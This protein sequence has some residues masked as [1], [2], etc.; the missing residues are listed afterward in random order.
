MP[1]WATAQWRW[2][3]DI[4]ASLGHAVHAIDPEP[5]LPDMV[6]A[7]N[8]AAVIGGKVLGAR[9]RHPQRRPESA[10]YLSWFRRCGYPVAP[11]ALRQ[12]GRG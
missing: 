2:L 3:R 9:F 1:R 8:G 11:P 4:Y 5:G 6:F 10:A 12:R 7:A